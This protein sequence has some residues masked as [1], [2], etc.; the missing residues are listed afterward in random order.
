VLA[1]CGSSGPTIPKSKLSKLVLQR[2]DVSQAF[3]PFY[4]GPLLRTDQTPRRG[5]PQR[6]GREGGWIARFH[7]GG[8]PRTRG[9]VVAASRVDL[10]KDR[11]D[12]KRDLALYAADFDSGVGKRIDIPKLGDDAVG[13]V[14]TQGGSV[15]VVSYAVA[16]RRFNATAEIEANGFARRL[17]LGDVLA[18]ARKQ[19][20]RLRAA[21][22]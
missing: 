20:A 22:G 9:P 13:T 10:F 18:L 19:D 16:W 2:A 15:R 11:G 5:D 3:S 8:S 12:A 4:V 17:T 6:F 1:G 14:S 7:R 21:A